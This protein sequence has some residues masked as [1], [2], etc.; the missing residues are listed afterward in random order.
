LKSTYYNPGEEIKI[1]VTMFDGAANPKPGQSLFK[2]IEA[3]ERGP[4]LH[5]SLVVEVSHA[6]SVFGFICSAWPD[7]LVVENAFPLRQSG[8]SGMPYMGRNFK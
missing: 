7:S 5:I 1:D 4:R 2:K 8:S 3:Y 6:G